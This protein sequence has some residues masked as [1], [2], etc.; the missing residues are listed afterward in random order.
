MAA[1]NAGPYDLI[2]RN[3][4]LYDG[5]GGAPFIGDVAVADD[6]L[7]LVG[8]AGRARGREEIDAAGLAV[9]PG[10][11]NILSWAGEALLHDGRSQS[12]IRQGVTLEVMGEGRSMGPLNETIRREMRRRQGDIQYEITWTTLDE[13]LRELV[14]RGVSANVASF[15]GAATVRTHE[16]G[17]EDRPPTPAELEAMRAHV[18]RAMAEGAVGLSSALIYAPGSY[19]ATEELI[20]LAEVVAAYDGLYISHIRNEGARLLPALEE[21][22]HIVRAAGVRGEIYHL[23]AAGL[24]NWHL[25]TEAIDRIE[26]A[27][28]VGLDITADIY[29]YAASST[30]LNAVMPGWVQEGGLDAWRQRLQDPEIRA[31]VKAEMLDPEPGWENMFTDTGPERMAL[32]GFRSEA[33]RPLTGQTLAEVAAARGASPAETAMDL[34]VEDES[35]VQVVYHSMSEENVRCKIRLPWVSFC[36]DARS[37]APEG[38]FLRSSTHPRAYGAFAR[39]LGRYVRDE[40]LIPLQEAIRRLT[41]LPA[42]R[43]RLQD[44]GLLAPGYFGDVVVFD[45]GTIQDHATYEAPHQYSSGVRHVLVN[46]TLVLR[47]G[48]HTGALPGRVVRGPGYKNRR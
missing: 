24:P 41:S 5:R 35:S 42:S 29:P 13:F 28:A 33:L 6:R 22:T 34:V 25:L 3:G 21:F 1:E 19:A 16:L 10:F 17:Y 7:A 44:R 32:V 15:V 9:A 31:R 26:E 46:G 27:R 37:L 39:L 30:G 23:K 40:E 45:P 36:S 14:R 2:I 20:A 18:R 12:D 8:D 38:I 48:E 11:V 43:L 4:T 47:E